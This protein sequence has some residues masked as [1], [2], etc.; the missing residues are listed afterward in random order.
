MGIKVLVR[1]LQLGP[2]TRFRARLFGSIYSSFGSPQGAFSIHGPIAGSYVVI[3]SYAR[4]SIVR[5]GWFGAAFL[6]L[7]YSFCRAILYGVGVDDFPIVIG[8]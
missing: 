4:P 8:S 1:R 2:R 7:Y 5:C 6:Y 3:T